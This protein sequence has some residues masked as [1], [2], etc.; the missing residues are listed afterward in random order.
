MEEGTK[1]KVSATTGFI[2]GQLMMFISIYY[3]PLH[4]ALG[5]PHTITVLVQIN[6]RILGRGI[7][8][9]K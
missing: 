7:I 6:R 1:K 3:A 5:R 4:L 8:R 9:E 2:M